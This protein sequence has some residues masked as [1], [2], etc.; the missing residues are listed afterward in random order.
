M[1]I[2]GVC[3]ILVFLVYCRGDA[4]HPNITELMKTFFKNADIHVS[5]KHIGSKLQSAKI[6][7]YKVDI[8]SS[9]VVNASIAKPMKRNAS[10]SVDCSEILKHYPNTRNVNG[11]YTIFPQRSHGQ[12]VFCDM[13]TKGGGWTVIHNR[14]DRTTD[15]YRTW[16]EYSAGFGNSSHNYWIG[17][18][19]IHLLTKNKLQKLR[20]E[21]QRF[22][23]EK[24]YAEYS[25]FLVGNGNT[26]YKLTVSGFKGNIG[27]GLVNQNEMKFTTKDQDNDIYNDYNCATLWH[28]AWWYKSCHTSNLNGVYARTSVIGAKYN[29]WYTWKTQYESLKTTRMMIRPADLG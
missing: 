19:I 21:L 1:N 16:K 5:W 17:N 12:K 8:L 6:Q 22:S 29:A 28:A 4:N 26:K 7:N 15:F 25:S 3:L 24:G 11:V 20:V 13:T 27:D 9:Y 23:G 14:V 18:D 2:P 10:A